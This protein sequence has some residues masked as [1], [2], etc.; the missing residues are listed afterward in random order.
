MRLTS[1]CSAIHIYQ[2]YA[3]TTCYISDPTHLRITKSFK[4]H[5]NPT[6]GIRSQFVH[7]LDASPFADSVRRALLTSELQE[8][9]ANAPPAPNDMAHAN[10]RE[11][12]AK[13]TG[14]VYSASSSKGKSNRR[15]PT[16]ED[17]NCTICYDIMLGT[18]DSELFFCDTCGHCFH[19]E[20]IGRC[21]SS[22]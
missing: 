16:E 22:F 1:S 14:K 17:P 15:P 2:G 20:C 8:V 18:A 5:T 9:F 12:Y 11:A 7:I 13:A 21:K 4:F 10:V 19:K 3:R 6:S